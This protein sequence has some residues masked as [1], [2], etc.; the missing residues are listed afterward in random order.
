MEIG[1]NGEGGL[2]PELSKELL[3]DAYGKH[4][5]LFQI[6]DH[7]Q[8]IPFDFNTSCWQGPELQQIYFK[9]FLN[10]DYNYWRRGVFHYA[11]I[12]YRADDYP[13]FAWA[14]MVG[15][16]DGT[17]HF[18]ENRN[19]RVSIYGDC[20]QVS[21]RHHDRLPYKHYLLYSIVQKTFNI[22]EQR[23]I[24]YATAMMHETGHVLGIYHDNVE[25]CDNHSAVWPWQKGWWIWKSYRSC[26]NYGYMY[27]LVDYSNGENGKYDNDDWNTIDLTRFQ[28]ERNPYFNGF[29]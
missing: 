23:A 20:F 17:W 8:V 22:K 14:S 7:G 16:W 19:N 10:E 5:I 26:M 28:Q 15:N 3:W 12:I 25:G 27:Q 24:V 18:S 1:P 6:D 9:Y 11:P 13:G 2:I 29:E 4:N 21:T